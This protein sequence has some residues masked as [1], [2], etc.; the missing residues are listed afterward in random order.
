[1]T[2]EQKAKQNVNCD[3]DDCDWSDDET[4][5]LRDD[6]RF[7]GDDID[8]VDAE[9][10]RVRCFES[11]QAVVYAHRKLLEECVLPEAWYERGERL[12]VLSAAPV[13]RESFDASASRPFARMLDVAGG[14]NNNNINVNRVGGSSNSNDRHDEGAGDN[15]GKQSGAGFFLSGGGLGSGSSTTRKRSPMFRVNL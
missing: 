10:E 13:Q 5:R 1:M 11:L 7:C 2:E 3:D 12:H 6:V 15:N 8:G 14:D 4:L 9:S